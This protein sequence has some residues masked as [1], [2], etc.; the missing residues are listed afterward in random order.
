MSYPDPD[1]F[2]DENYGGAVFI[3]GMVVLVLWFLFV[4]NP[5]G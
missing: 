4:G 1:D 3:A 2:D 5:Y